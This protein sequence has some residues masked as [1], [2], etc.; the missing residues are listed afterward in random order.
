MFSNF[1]SKAD[2][3]STTPV[4]SSAQRNIKTKVVELYPGLAPFV[5]EIIPKKS[6]L[7]LSKCEDRVS[8]YSV[9]NKVVF[10]QHFD[11]D[12]IPSLRLVHLYP[13]AFTKVGVDRGAIKFVYVVGWSK[14]NSYLT[15]TDSVVQILWLPA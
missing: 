9:D 8:L 12:L 15:L 11:D 10:F 1:K 5:D 2:I 7:T 14:M 6:Q 13:E 3:R 4:K